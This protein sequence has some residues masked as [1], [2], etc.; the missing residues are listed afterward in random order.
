M[1]RW[2]G[3]GHAVELTLERFH[4]WRHCSLRQK[5]SRVRSIVESRFA[6]CREVLRAASRSHRSVFGETETEIGG[7]GL[8]VPT[9]KRDSRTPWV[10][11]AERGRSRGRPDHCLELISLTSFVLGSAGTKS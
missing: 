4:K 10:Q 3:V 6:R 2:T 8:P 9:K 5:Q 7:G 1:A 11:A